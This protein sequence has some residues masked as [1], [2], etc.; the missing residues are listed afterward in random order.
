MFFARLLACVLIAIFASGTSALAQSSKE[1][2]PQKASATP[3]YK[4]YIVV[5]ASSG[6]VLLADE[7]DA[8]SPP[9]SVTKLMTFL[10]VHERIK[11]GALALDTVVPITVDD[12]NMGGSQVYLDPREK[13]SVDELLYALMVQS[14]N[15][16]ATALARAAFGSREVFI[17]AMNA[18]AREL[19]MKN[20]V[21][22]TPHGLPPASRKLSES[23]ITT[24]RDLALLS[25]ELLQNTD[26]LR[27]SS[28]QQRPFGAGQRE[29]PMLMD[30]HNNLVGKVEGVD[31]LKTGFTNSAGYCIAATAERNG[32]RVIVAIMGCPTAAGRDRKVTAL[33]AEGFAKLPA[34]PAAPASPI[35]A[36]D[37][38]PVR[39]AKPDTPV[40]AAPISPAPS[41]AGSEK[42]A[43]KFTVPKTPPQKNTGQR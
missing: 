13:F 37:A 21:F 31:G 10:L 16:A 19:G 6:E 22:R 24:P 33:F 8:T 26:V 43:V 23:D 1:K 41:P 11:A 39:A 28:V 15:D 18:R 17:E 38:S 2:K 12:Y 25:R 3:P 14:A 27:Y 34:A 36:P 42:P 35:S 4:G 40:E 9:A 32:R 29:K 30:N 7:P 5:D 20:T